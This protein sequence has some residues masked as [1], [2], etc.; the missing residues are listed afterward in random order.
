M[1][2][3]IITRWIHPPIPDRRFDY[4]A[5]HEGREESGHYGWGRTE[6]EALADLQQL[7]EERAEAIEGEKSC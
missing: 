4:C 2:G 7:D 6:A 1:R 5:F 3:K